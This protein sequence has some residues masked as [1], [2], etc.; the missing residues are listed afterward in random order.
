MYSAVY[1]R[2]VSFGV[3]F[4]SEGDYGMIIVLSMI[5]SLLALYTKLKG[6]NVSIILAEMVRLGTRDKKF[7][8]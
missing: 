1:R 5:N 8:P 7:I 6:A 3:T 4:T 2:H